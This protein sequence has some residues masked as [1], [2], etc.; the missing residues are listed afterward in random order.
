MVIDTNVLVSSLIG[1]G[2]PHRVV[3]SVLL[4]RIFQFCI[5]AE[6]WEEYDEVL[7][8]ERFLKFENFSKNA[9][10]LLRDIDVVAIY[11]QPFT[12]LTIIKDASDNKFLELA[13][14]CR[15]DFLITGNTNDFTFSEYKSTKIVTPKQFWEDYFLKMN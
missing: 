9:D 5:S 6:V 13:E 12:T 8:R 7:H 14:A 3:K 15:A 2:Y 10:S 11:Y 4:N 1:K